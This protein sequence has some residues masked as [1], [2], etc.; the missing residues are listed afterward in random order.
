MASRYLCGPWAPATDAMRYLTGPARC[1]SPETA[2]RFRL[3]CVPKEVW[4]ESIPG[5]LSQYGKPRGFVCPRGILIP[6]LRPGSTFEVPVWGG[7]IVRR[8]TPDFRGDDKPKKY[9]NIAGMDSGLLYP[10][11]DLRADGRSAL[12]VTEGEFDAL[13]AIQELGG[14]ADHVGLAITTLGSA[15]SRCLSPETLARVAGFPRLIL[16]FDADRAGDKAATFWSEQF[17]HAARLTFPG[18]NDLTE[19]VATAGGTALR[20]QILDS[21]QFDDI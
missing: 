18:A 17:P 8:L 15:A 10:D 6:K 1:L 13:L 2:R 4:S 20:T 3:G 16:A 12:L 14:L 21:I 5:L 19:Y 7:A 9:Q 11:P